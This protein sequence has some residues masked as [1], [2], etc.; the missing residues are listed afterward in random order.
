MHIPA[1]SFI[2]R[3]A[4]SHVDRLLLLTYRILDAYRTHLYKAPSVSMYAHIATE[5]KIWIN[6][7]YTMK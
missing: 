2:S 1:A 6:Y 7:R 4:V 3:A 5:P